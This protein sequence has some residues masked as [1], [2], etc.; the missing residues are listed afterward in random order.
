[1]EPFPCTDILLTKRG[2][3]FSP[4]PAADQLRYLYEKQSYPLSE[5]QK[6]VIAATE[7]LIVFRSNN[8]E[9]GRSLYSTAVRGFERI[10]DFRAAAMATYFWAIEGKH[11]RA[12]IA[13]SIDE[14]AKKRIS[15][16]NVFELEG[17]VK[18]L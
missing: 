18:K 1:M 6:F 3:T 10:N 17:L 15:R 4:S 8:I 11:I 9:K 14:D 5:R 13:T 12:Q 7:G 16:Y 2:R